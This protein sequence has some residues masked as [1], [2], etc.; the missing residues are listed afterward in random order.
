MLP[1]DGTLTNTALPRPFMW[2]MRSATDLLTDYERG[3]AGINDA[4]QGLDAQQWT[5]TYTAPDVIVTD[6]TGHETML[7]SQP[8]ITELALAFDQN[9]HPFV[10]FVDGV[11][12]HYW[13]FDTTSGAQVFT[14]LPL[15]ATHPRA[16]IDDHR[17]LEI[18]MSDIILAYQRGGAL[19]YRQQRDRFA[20]EYLL[21][22][23]A[24]GELVSVGMSTGLRLQFAIYPAS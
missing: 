10:A 3:G 12:A 16:C 5:L 21:M 2:P 13:W 6:E 17:A 8:G 9:M 20:T 14:D 18:A 22:A 7:F 4:G 23:D 19:Y 24:G 11:G 15:D 1:G